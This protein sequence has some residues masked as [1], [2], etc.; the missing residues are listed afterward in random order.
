MSEARQREP[1]AA[2]RQERLQRRL[3]RARPSP[4]A[5][6]LVALGVEQVLVQ[7]DVCEDL[8][9]LAGGRLQERAR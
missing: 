4:R 9:L 1:V 7:R 6:P 2:A 5:Q 3:V 8:A